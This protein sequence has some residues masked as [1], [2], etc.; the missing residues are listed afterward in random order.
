MFEIKNKLFLAPLAGIT[1]IHFRNIC[2]QFGADIVYTELISVEGLNFQ[3]QKTYKLLNFSENERPIGI[4]LFGSKP[5]SFAKAV[6]VVEKLK[7]DFIDLNLG[8]SVKKV[9]KSGAGSILL[10]DIKKVQRII[11][12]MKENTYIP[13]TAKIRLGWKEN[14]GIE[15]AQALEEVGIEF[16]VIHGRLAKQQFTGK[17]DWYSIG[18]IAKSVN[19]PII[20]NGDIFTAEDAIEKLNKYPIASIMIGRG[21]LG[22]PWIFK[23]IKELMSKNSILTKP[24]IKDKINILKKHYNMAYKDAP[25]ENTIKYMRKHFHWYVKGIPNIKKYKILINKTVNFNEVKNILNEIIK[26]AQ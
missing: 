6:K 7:P 15:I 19:I 18:K 4:Q 25:N 8:C 11:I 5:E 23:Q 22:N 16:L 26:E 12:A 24:S 9:N 1:D 14:Y 3:S 20:G 2:K 13:I 10:Q 17:A 21:V